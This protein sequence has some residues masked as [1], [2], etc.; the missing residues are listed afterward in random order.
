MNGP[1]QSWLFIPIKK[2]KASIPNSEAVSKSNF[3]ATSHECYHVIE[4]L[5]K[6]SK[7]K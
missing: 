1:L 5:G 2:G 7:F 3:Y 6:F 4:A